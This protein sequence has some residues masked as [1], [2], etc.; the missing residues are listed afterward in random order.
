MSVSQDETAHH[1]PSVIPLKWVAK[2]TTTRNITPFVRQ[3]PLELHVQ[4]ALYLSCI[5]IRLYSLVSRMLNRDGFGSF[6][7]AVSVVPRRRHR[8]IK[9]F[10]LILK[11]NPTR[12]ACIRQVTF[13]PETSVLRGDFRAIVDIF[14]NIPTENFGHSWRKGCV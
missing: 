1:L 5:Y 8:G 10:A 7:R 3:F 2:A 6:W 11:R 12:A 9:G 4:F 14:P 13:M